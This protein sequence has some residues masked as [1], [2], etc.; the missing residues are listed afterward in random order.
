MFFFFNFDSE[1]Y[2][3]EPRVLLHIHISAQ[4]CYTTRFSNVPVI[5]YIL[6]YSV[7]FA[8]ILESTVWNENETLK[9]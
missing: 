7:Y 8:A 2:N 1:N 5:A 4:Y 6:Q 9:T 3:D